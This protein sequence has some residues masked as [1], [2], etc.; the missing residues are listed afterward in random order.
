MDTGGAGASSGRTGPG[1]VW[2]GGHMPGVLRYGPAGD[3]GSA[4]PWADLSGLAGR[5]RPVRPH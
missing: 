1:P 4:L 2:Q 5:K 3:T